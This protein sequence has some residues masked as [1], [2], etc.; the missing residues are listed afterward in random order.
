MYRMVLEPTANTPNLEGKQYQTHMHILEYNDRK[1]FN[2][3]H[4]FTFI[5]LSI[6]L[7]R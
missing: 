2:E 7:G 6:F 3:S 4:S 5:G 1:H